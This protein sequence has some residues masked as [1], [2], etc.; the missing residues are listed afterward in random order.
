MD[1]AAPKPAASAPPANVVVREAGLGDVEVLARIGMNSF[2]ETYGPYSD[3]AD[4]DAH[5][6]E[7]FSAAAVRSEINSARSKFLLAQ[8]DAEPGGMLKYR[9]AACPVPGGDSN[10]IEIQQL[11][12]LTHMQRHGLGRKLAQGVL[13]AAAQSEVD[14]VWLSAWEDADW[15]TSFYERMGFNAIGKVAFKL[16]AS[17]YTDFLMWRPIGK[18]TS[19]EADHG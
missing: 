16:G 13:T 12:V 11:Y 15:A 10:A 6:E 17:S 4:I 3:A 8:V 18:Q 7:Y 5:I 1:D 19:G 2:R 9:K 14:G